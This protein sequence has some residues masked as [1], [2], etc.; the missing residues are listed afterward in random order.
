MRFELITVEVTHGIASLTLSQPATR[1]GLHGQFCL[2]IID[3]LAKLGAR[4]DVRALILTGAGK[5]FCA[6]AD[7]GDAFKPDA[8]GKSVGQ[9]GAQLMEER[10]NAVILG[11]QKFPHP[12]VAAVNGAAAGAGISLALSADV[13]VA[14]RSAYFLAPFLPRLG[15]VPDMGATWFLP[16]HVGRARAKGMMLL[17]ERLPAEKALEWGLIW[18]CVDDEALMQEAKNIAL[19]LAEG[20]AHSALEA[21]RALDAAAAQGLSARLDYEKMQM[22]RFNGASHDLTGS[23]LGL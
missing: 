2:E 4:D 6:G 20:P 15:I 10:Y 23:V 16:Q 21:R 18:S 9:R 1:N 7:L 3:A 14:G 19:R 13:V 17:G 5:S 8:L 12:I 22:I 11:L